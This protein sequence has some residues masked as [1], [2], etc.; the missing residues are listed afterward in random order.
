MDVRSMEGVTPVIEH[1]GTTPVWWLV[2]PRQMQEATEG[3][4]LELVSEWIVEGGGMVDPHS[5]P[6]HEF[7]YVM[8]G[9]GIMTIDGEDRPIAQ[10]DLVYIPPDKVHSLRPIS[11]NAPIHCF[12]FAIGVKGAG[13][14]NYTTH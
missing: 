2:P 11:D 8:N 6:T 5:H 12:C 4:F 3:G 9:R 10:G 1:N 14:I 7:Y 13:A